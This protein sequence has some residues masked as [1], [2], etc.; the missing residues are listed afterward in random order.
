MRK[1]GME[2]KSI[3]NESAQKAM[4]NLGGAG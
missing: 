4:Q 3:T 1:R 2:R